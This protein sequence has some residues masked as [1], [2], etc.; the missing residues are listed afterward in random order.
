MCFYL[1]KYSDEIRRIHLNG[2]SGK[3][4]DPNHDSA[5]V[6]E[7]LKDVFSENSNLRLN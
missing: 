1:K 3:Y 2:T 4:L 5:L 7:E 6:L